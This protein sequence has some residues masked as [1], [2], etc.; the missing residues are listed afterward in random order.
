VNVGQ[1]L[2]IVKSSAWRRGATVDCDLAVRNEP[3]VKVKILSYADG[4]KSMDLATI[5]AKVNAEYARLHVRTKRVVVLSFHL[6]VDQGFAFHVYRDC[7]PARRHLQWTKIALLYHEL[8]A[9]SLPEWLIFVDA[10]EVF[11]EHGMMFFFFVRSV[12]FLV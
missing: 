3:G 7:R 5:S 6:T 11:A 2:A 1:G 4:H 10:D 12:F 9:P 8:Q